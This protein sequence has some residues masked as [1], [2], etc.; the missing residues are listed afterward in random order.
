MLGVL[1]I[2]AKRQLHR[3]PKDCGKL[4][5]FEEKDITICSELLFGGIR[6]Q[7]R[8]EQGPCLKAGRDARHSDLQRGALNAGLQPSENRRTTDR[9]RNSFFLFTLQENRKS[10][11]TLLGRVVEHQGYILLEFRAFSQILW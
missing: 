1:E 8:N 9:G 2:C 7:E 6:K 4:Q 11:R 10:R 3:A 5:L